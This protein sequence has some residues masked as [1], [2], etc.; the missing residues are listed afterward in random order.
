L[1]GKEIFLH[2]GGKSFHYIPA[3]NEHPDWIEAIGNIALANLGDWVSETWDQ[4][5]ANQALE[6]SKRRA[7]RLG[8]AN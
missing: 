8:A 2:A 6:D 5:L 1:E 3:L 4:T 7:A